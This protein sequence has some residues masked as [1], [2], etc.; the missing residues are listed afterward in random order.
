[1]ARDY[2][3]GLLKKVTGLGF[4]EWIHNYVDNLDK[5]KFNPEIVI[6]HLQI[7]LLYNEY[8]E[9]QAKDVPIKDKYNVPED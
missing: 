5:D 1:M 8:K 7:D 9:Y 2:A 4:I 3:R 6:Q